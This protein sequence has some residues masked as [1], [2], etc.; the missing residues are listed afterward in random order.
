MRDTL[1]T[2]RDRLEDSNPHAAQTLTDRV[3]ARLPL[4]RQL[5]GVGMAALLGRLAPGV[6]LGVAGG[7]ASSGGPATHTRLGFQSVPLDGQ[8][9]VSVPAG[10]VVQV[11]F[12]WGDPVGVPGAMPPFRP[13]A[14]NSAEEQALQAGMHHDGLH[15][16]PLEGARRGLLCV[17]HEYVDDGLLHV[18]GQVP[19]TAEK[20]AKSQAAHGVSVIEVEA[21]GARFEVARP[22]RFARRITAT[23]PCAIAGPARG[24]RL[25][26]TAADPEGRRVLGTLANCAHGATP[27]GTYLTCE[28]N[29]RDYFRGPEAPNAHE[30]RWGLRPRDLWYRWSEHDERFDARRHPNEPNRF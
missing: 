7:C 21:R 13:D 18:G 28:E 10:Y 11:L 12:R 27:W 4:R 14:S 16:F 26:R 15:Y 22:S 20:V 2:T 29:F 5:L 3:A 8:D 23:T 9:R 6:G 19:W 25:L 17:N 30:Q 1:E 24:H